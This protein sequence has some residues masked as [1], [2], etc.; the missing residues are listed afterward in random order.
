M[1]ILIHQQLE[2]IDSTEMRE[3]GYVHHVDCHMGKGTFLRLVERKLSRWPTTFRV[4]L[5]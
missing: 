4:P 3:Q 2:D 1:G 5:L